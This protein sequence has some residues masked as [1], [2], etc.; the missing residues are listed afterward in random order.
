MSAMELEWRSHVVG[1]VQEKGGDVLPAAVMEPGR[2]PG[3][4]ARV[5]RLLD[6]FV[7]APTYLGLTQ[8][9]DRAGLPK[10]TTHRLLATF[11]REGYVRRVGDSYSLTNRAFEVGNSVVSCR[12]N[13]LREVATP[14]LVDLFNQTRQ[15]VHLAIL[16]GGTEVLYLEKIF[17][18][19]SVRTSTA[20]G[21]R[22]PAHATALGKA[23]VAF[24][25]AE[26][27]EQMLAGPLQSYTSRTFATRCALEKQLDAVRTLGYAVDRGEYTDRL[28]CVAAPI[29]DKAGL[30]I[31][32]ISMSTT[33]RSEIIGT[34]ARHVVQTAGAVSRDLGRWG[35]VAD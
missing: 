29:R 15:T 1:S 24:S 34:H 23:M 9:A 17:G 27:R 13:G 7:G 4:A 5:L 12:P 8:L 10:S 20:V 22:R 2:H 18:H 26:T 11:V 16:Q 3:A 21:A 14:H 28:T 35:F 32:A 33:G 25:P 31:A 19:S 30:A 6:T